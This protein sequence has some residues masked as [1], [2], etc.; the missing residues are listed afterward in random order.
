MELKG[1]TNLLYDGKKILIT[2]DSRGVGSG[3]ANHF[4][5]QGATV[6]GFSR[7]SSTTS[8]KNYIHITVDLNSV[9]DISNG[10]KKIKENTKT[11]DILINNAAV[12]TS[13]YALIMPIKSAD[14]MIRINILAPFIV[15]REAAKLMKNNKWGRIIGMSSMA[16]S[17]EPMGDSIYAAS[18]AALEKINNVLAKELAGFNITCNSIGISAIESDM[19][20]QLPRD[21]INDII[22]KLPINRFAKIQD[23]INV[24]DFYSSD[25]S[26]LITA[27]TIYLGG[28]N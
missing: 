24:V 14:A 5:S 1:M 17:L 11:L 9:E 3:L 26:S 23:I 8:H 16:V 20:A 19:L 27:Q 6:Y 12:L 22:A 28:V 15:A 13:Q 10:F 7:V 25:S 2:G 18:K 4:L 21:K